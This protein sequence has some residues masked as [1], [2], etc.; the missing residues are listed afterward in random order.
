MRE[1][2]CEFC[3]DYQL[4]KE[5][6]N[7]L[8]HHDYFAAMVVISMVD[9]HERARMTHRPRELVYCPTCGQRLL[10]EETQNNELKPCPNPKCKSDLIDISVIS[11]SLGVKK[12]RAYCCT[13][14]NS[15]RWQTSE[16]KAISAW[17]K[18]CEKEDK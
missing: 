18:R 10:R 8:I 9:G 5:L 13:C 6:Q 7:R 15:T 3:E 12:F 14:K 16:T 2:K 11:D 4:S 1:K 17:N